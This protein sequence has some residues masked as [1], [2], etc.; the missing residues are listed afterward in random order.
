MIS[1]KIGGYVTLSMSQSDL[2]LSLYKYL[3]DIMFLEKE[4]ISMQELLGIEKLK[5]KLARKK[6]RVNLRYEFYDQKY[7]PDDNGI[8]TPQTNAFRIDPIVGWC[9]KSVDAI[10]DRLSF[11][12]FKNDKFDLMDIFK[13]NNPD[14]LFDS[15]ILS[16]LISSCC[17]IYVS[18]DDD[19]YPLLQVIDGANATGVMDV[20]TGMLNEGYAIL[21]TD[22]NGKPTIEAYFTSTYTEYYEKGKEPYTIDNPS[23]YP[24]LVPIVYKPSD[25]RPFG[26]SRI[27]RSSMDIVQNACKTIRRAE[28]S[29]EFYSFPQKYIVGLSNDADGF[30]KFKA[31]MSSLIQINKDEDGDKPTLG[32]F[33]QQ[34]MAPHLDQFQ[35][36]VKQFC[37]ESGLTSDDL[38]FVSDNPSSAEAIKA[39]HES[40]KLVARKAQKTFGR[41]FL[42]TGFVARC[43]M[44]E[45]KYKRNVLYMTEPEWYPIFEPDASM[46]S[47]IG[48]GAIKLNQAVPG[49]INKD[50]LEELTGFP[51]SQLDQI[52]SGEQ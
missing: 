49:Y 43:L 28:I 46:L 31:T 20:K 17:F 48:D 15:A 25:T 39:S 50:N 24:L 7:K 38:G 44:D 29:S 10:A 37:G 51:S 35:L 42:N 23:G 5:N 30:D 14:T 4:R 3:A 47:S 9:T 1:K 45:Y 12:G 19:G 36:Y 40:L 11:K 33:S 32:Q 21:D 22:E 6:I 41:G 2:H 34:S 8:S 18:K 27:T 52:E 13:M 26:H 16:A